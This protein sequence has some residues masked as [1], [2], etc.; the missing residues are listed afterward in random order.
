MSEDATR[1]ANV[2]LTANVDGYRQ[3]TQ[4]ATQ[5]TNTL[6]ASV[7]ALASKLD[8]LQRRVS[9]RLTL[10]GA[11]DLAM[12]TSMVAVTASY[13]KQLSHLT[14]QS[15][16]TGRSMGAISNN[17]RQM[18]RDLPVARGEITA[19]AT[20]IS[21]MGVTSARDISGLTETFTKTA[22]AAGESAIA[23]GSSMTMLSR[24]M[25]TLAGGAP[26][27]QKYTDSLL[28]VSAAAGVSAQAVADFANSIAP[29]ANV[30]GMTQTQ[31]L[32]LSSAFVQA[33]NDGYAAA[34]T[35]NKMLSDI[36]QTTSVGGVG[37]DKYASLLGV[38]VSQFKAMPAAD[39]I[40]GIF[41]AINAA[42]PTSIAILDQMGY[43]GI[44]ATK[45]IQSM[46]AQAGGLEK[47]VQT[48]T[49]AYGNDATNTGAAAAM[50]GLTDQM[51]RFGNIAEDMATSI[52]AG[53]ITPL[54]GALGVL[55]NILAQGAKLTGVF[56]AGGALAGLGGAAAMGAGTIGTIASYAALPVALRWLW[57]S[58]PMGALREGRRVAAGTAMPGEYSA[59]MRQVG[60]GPDDPGFDPKVKPAGPLERLM[61]GAGTSAGAHM[62]SGGTGP[63]L[64][65]RAG[66]PF[67]MAKVFADSYREFYAE[68]GT[69]G[70]DRKSSPTNLLGLQRGA[71]MKAI[72]STESFA[73]AV[74]QASVA[75]AKYT[76]TQAKAGIG[77]AVSGAGPA[78][79][80]LGS[81]ALGFLGGPWG[82]ALMAGM[83]GLALKSKL[84]E[85]QANLDS[86]AKTDQFYNQMVPYTTQ[87]GIATTSLVA[88]TGQLNYAGVAAKTISEALTRASNT[89]TGKGTPTNTN[90][91]AI[92]SAAQGA[93]YLRTL[94]T[95]DPQVVQGAAQDV[96]RVLG[97]V[98]GQKALD[99]YQSSQSGNNA[100]IAALA[101]GVG[102]PEGQGGM[103]WWDSLAV[104]QGWTPGTRS[105]QATQLTISGIMANTNRYSQS[106]DKAK[107]QAQANGI[108]QA[109]DAVLK[110]NGT[111]N[112]KITAIDLI[113][114]QFE[115]PSDWYSGNVSQITDAHSFQ[116]LVGA[117]KPLGQWSQQSTVKQGV[118]WFSDPDKALNSAMTGN[119]N[120]ET[121]GLTGMGIN[122][123]SSAVTG[124]LPVT[125]GHPNDATAQGKAID[126]L[127]A[128]ARQKAKGQVSAA[129]ARIAKRMGLKVTDPR[130]I[131]AAGTV[132][133]YAN[134]NLANV[135][136]VVTDPNDP[137]YGPLNTASSNA[138]SLVG[139]D[140]SL[141]GVTQ[142][143]VQKLSSSRTQM[144]LA[145]SAVDD[146][147]NRDESK[148][149]NLIS[150]KANYKQQVAGYT[151]Y[152]QQM[153]Q[154]QEQFQLQSKRSDEDY[155][156]QMGYSA[157]DFYKG[158]RR[159]RADFNLSMSRQ[160][161]DT[162]KTIY[163]PMIRVQSQYTTDVGTLKQNMSEQTRMIKQQVANLRKLKRLGLSQSTIDMLQLADPANAQQVEEL[164]QEMTKTDAATLNKQASQRQSATKSLTQSDLNQ[165][166]TRAVADFNK[167]VSRS[168]A[169]YKTGVDRM[170]QAHKTQLARAKE[171]LALM[172]KEYVGD[173]TTMFNK[174][175]ALVKSNLGKTA[176]L[177]MDELNAIK[178]AF[179]EFFTSLPTPKGLS[180]GA[181]GGARAA[182]VSAHAAHVA[183]T[184]H[185]S[186]TTHTTQ[187]NVTINGGVTIPSVKPADTAKVL[188]DV[189]RMKKLKHV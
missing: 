100:D 157:A 72:T 180:P 55:N 96:L 113:T 53:L 75:T 22:A 37:L 1:N 182:G 62:P 169:D 107:Y 92:T 160:L 91:N 142:T 153:V 7:D 123:K 101:K 42:G 121:T 147:N 34:T 146:P 15:A 13:E 186:H 2:N 78:L 116:D 134:Q 52:G 6:I 154:A 90:V 80:G 43:D 156:L 109:I 8:G 179:P 84:D 86:R 132:N 103:H 87:L 82:I 24:Q 165:G 20:A 129:R 66:I 155:K 114:Q 148:Y 136:G 105:D 3:S 70:F 11:A 14:A 45:A 125:G 54:T 120:P 33:G 61:Y 168:V 189:A 139:N 4:G 58:K 88:F 27:M 32:G 124:L 23:I 9:K 30:A 99:Q 85:N 187:H 185:V 60:L 74:A 188:A 57:N 21:K 50:G 108:R 31:V 73:K 49:G 47:L 145:Q 110:G 184:T 151:Q 141:Q 65:A 71:T 67:R 144:G 140:L 17:I 133:D 95:V 167:S 104:K 158:Q 174:A 76:A 173:F 106:G 64:G 19:T 127:Y 18:T 172:S 68:A 89:V 98:E 170:A 128:Q 117:S 46:A 56:S 81:S 143:R 36:V 130:V 26:Q 63:G 5:D 171:D 29:I 79:R 111:A 94:G 175:Q 163:N 166:Y 159:S 48:A 149:S 119:T 112:Q 183:H 176:N 177:T 51:Q 16:I 122:L 126:Y 25:G 38:T 59:R 10:F 77:A 97:P 69:P 12:M 41:K 118:D 152:L 137:T 135:R 138:Q 39:K 181:R 93:S 178:T 164:T 162:A 131:A 115:L 150:A 44:R 35:F 28:S 161:Q 83:G 102:N 40:T